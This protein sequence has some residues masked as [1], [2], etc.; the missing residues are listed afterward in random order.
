MYAVIETGNKQYIV[1]KG[2]TIDVELLA[3]EPGKK[4]DIENV[5][6]VSKRG[7]IEIGK[8]YIKNAKVVAKVLENVLGEKL[9]VFKYK[10]KTRYHRKTGHRQKLTR[11]EIED[12]KVSEAKKTKE[13]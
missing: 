3:T 6:L 12:I 4:I 9:T 7:H 1:S 5:L 11:L 10:S 8:P 13:E 2:D